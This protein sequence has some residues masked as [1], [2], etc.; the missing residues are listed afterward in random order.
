MLSNRAVWHRRL[1]WTL[2]A[3][4]ILITLFAA[5]EATKAALGKHLLQNL[6]LLRAQQAIIAAERLKLKRPVS[7]N[8][9]TRSGASE[10]A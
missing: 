9:L 4:A 10:L 6:D 8:P 2:T 5:W 7:T 1:A 3:V